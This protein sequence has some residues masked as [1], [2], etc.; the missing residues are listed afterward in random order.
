LIVDM[1]KESG[2]EPKVS[3]SGFELLK[4]ISEHKDQIEYVISDWSMPGISGEELFQKLRFQLPHAKLIVTSGFFLEENKPLEANAVLHKPFGPDQLI[5]LMKRLTVE[6]N[7]TEP[8]F[9][10]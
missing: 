6:G 4:L 9:T 3:T 2:F 10:S 5:D 7:C 8:Y 1:L